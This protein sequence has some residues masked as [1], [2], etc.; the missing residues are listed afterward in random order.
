[1]NGLTIT[2]S[3]FKA[4]N[5]IN[6]DLVIFDNLEYIKSH[7]TKWKLNVRIQYGWLIGLTAI[8]GWLIKSIIN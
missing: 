7:I 3:Q 1:M 5:R 2:R 6:K 8:G 4:M